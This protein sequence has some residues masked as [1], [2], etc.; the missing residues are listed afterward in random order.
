[1]TALY[2]WWSERYAAFH[3]LITIKF[4]REEP[5]TSR[6]DDDDAVGSEVENACA[7]VV[8]GVGLTIGGGDF[9]MSEPLTFSCLL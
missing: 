5:P 3:R 9:L 1:M 6:D 7:A 4:R 8:V 2:T